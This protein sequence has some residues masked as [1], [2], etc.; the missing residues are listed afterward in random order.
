MGEV[1]TAAETDARGRAVRSRGPWA[2]AFARFRRQWL[3][4]VALGVLVIV[5]GAGALAAHLSPYPFSAYD[6]LAANLP[7]TLEGHHFFGTDQIGRDLFS[8]TLF[9]I[10]SSLLV[11]V[12]VAAFATL[13]GIVVGGLAGYF[14]GWL[15]NA[16]MRLVELVVTIPALGVL[17]VAIIFLGVPTPR[18]AAEVLILYLWTGVARV[19]RAQFV[20]LRETEFVEAARAAGASGF[21]IVFRHLVP[22]AFGSIVVAAS[23]LVGQAILLDATLEF[24]DFGISGNTQPS[25]GNLIADATKYGGLDVDWWLYAMPASVIVL[26]LVCVNF[27]GDCLDEALNPTLHKTGIR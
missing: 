19:V 1:A 14:G 23:L 6:P 21:R 16:L 25:L 11:G 2:R 5:F 10:R 24:F 18:K 4:L 26:L 13:I 15:D 7:P 8:R 17:F 3:A 12:A 20:S 27:L 22:N 9:G